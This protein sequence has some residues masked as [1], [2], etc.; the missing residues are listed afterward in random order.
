MIMKRSM[1]S[2]I[3]ILIML[4]LAIGGSFA[5]NTFVGDGTGKVEADTIAELLDGDEVSFGSGNIS[6]NDSLYEN[7]GLD[8]VTMYLTIRKGNASEGTNHTWKEVN[9]HS[10][11]YYQEQGIDRYKVEALLQVGTENGVEPGNLGYGRTAPNATVQVRGQT[12]S[13]NKQKNYKIELK[14]NQGSWNGQKTIALNKHV[15][16]GLRYRNKLGFDLLSDI[17]ELMSLRTQFVHLYVK[18]LTAEDEGDEEDVLDEDVSDNE[19]AGEGSS[20]ETG[21][22]PDFVDYGLYTQVEQLN[23]TALRAH[24]LDRTGHLYKLNYFEFFRYEDVIKLESDPTFDRTAFESY[25]EIKGDNDH[26]KLIAMLEDLNDYSIPMENILNKYFDIKNLTY[27]LAF[28]LLT[29]NGDTQS[30]NT[31]IYSPQNSN[32]WYLYCWDLDATFRY[33]EN[34]LLGRSDLIGWELGVSNYWGNVLFKRCLKSDMFRRRLDVAV[35]NVKRKL[36]KEK[37]EGLIADY[38]TVVDEYLY[39]E[40]DVTYAPLTPSEYEQISGNLPNLVDFYYGKYQESLE[41]PLPFYIGTPVQNAEKITFGWDEAYDF[42]QD[43]IKYEVRLSDDLSFENI[44]YEYSGN[45]T[46]CAAAPLPE[47]QYFLEVIAVDEDGNRQ[48]AF[49]YYDS[50]MGKYYSTLCFYVDKKGNITR[51]VTSEGDN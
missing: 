22:E 8:V 42:Q 35:K 43:D 7:R 27:W 4:V 18:D 46:S 40:P 1:V 37:I 41:K 48:S 28:N 51:F 13:I 36:S 50:D 10:V 11:Y 49:D 34:I 21:D 25:L 26:S 2:I 20:D 5:Y 38:R 45:W 39:N 47:G 9:E 33:D 19:S 14:E 6:D 31:Y 17:D 16:D 15:S 12:S 23:K 44:I 30:R 29:G 24:G 3:L 32:K